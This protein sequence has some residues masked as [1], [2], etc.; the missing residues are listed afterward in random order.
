MS[1]DKNKKDQQQ[2]IEKPLFDVVFQMGVLKLALQDDYFCT[3]LVKYLAED[4][5]LDE[6]T[7]FDTDSLQEIF[8]IVVD[9]VQ[10]FKNRPTEG[11]V[12]QK[13][14][15]YPE[16]ERQDYNDL[17]DSILQQDT[18][19]EDY[20]RKFLQT[21]IQQVKMAKGFKKTRKV[22]KEHPEN[23][24]E[25]MQVVIDAIRRVSFDKEDVVTL[26]D[27]PALINEG[28]TLNT[29]KIPT[30]VKELDIDLVGGLPRENLTVVLAGT[31]VGKSL[32]CISLGC[33]A[34]QAV[35]EN[36]QNKG[37]KVLHINLEGQRDEAAK[38][39]AANLSQIGYGD[40]IRGS[41]DDA[42]RRRFEEVISKYGEDRLKIRNM[43]GFGATIEDLHV[44]L[45]EEYKNFRFD[46]VVVDYGQLLDSK[47]KTEGYRFT[48]SRVFRGLDS[49]SKEFSAVVITPAQ[50]TRNA[51]E[52]QNTTFKG[53]NSSGGQEDR[54]H[55]LRSTD[56]SEAFEIARVSGVILTL[57]RTEEEERTNR[58]RLY[59][60]KQRQGA[61]NKLYGLI[62]N[63]S[64]SNLITG[65]T[66]N[67]FEVVI[68]HSAVDS[69]I[70]KKGNSSAT[71]ASIKHLTDAKQNQILAA[72]KQDEEEFD[73]PIKFIDKLSQE[74]YTVRDE[75]SRI[76]SVYEDLREQDDYDKE[77][78][79]KMLNNLNLLKERLD[80]ILIE[81]RGMIGQAYPDANKE[82]YGLIKKQLDDMKKTN[83]NPN[84][85]QKLEK[86]VR[87]YE[88]GLGL[89]RGGH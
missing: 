75:L 50:S 76:N 36:G 18:H 48:M 49:I 19:N 69:K 1:N 33:N 71:L 65:K 87:H 15:E 53:R 79:D 85:I 54:S 11:Q 24:P 59:L 81:A 44:Y 31:N 22:F 26:K 82:T 35:D 70:D 52:N 3:Q 72:K 68:D 23:A 4:N 88:I 21:Y 8:K 46:M 67:P 41:F 12:R 5:D 30:G 66:Y 61:K 47:V 64:Q 6:Y 56:I 25:Y 2:E 86:I 13:F 73:G 32:F 55:I 58:L 51:Q 39:Y 27:L 38:R 80:A 84:D 17:L 63:Y 78:A 10:N 14:N 9:S 77:E 29:R 89:V 83:G 28:A 57:N 16:S 60:E 43:L 7:I 37:L 74:Y 20:Y 42:A 45:K 62:T 40:L 34:L